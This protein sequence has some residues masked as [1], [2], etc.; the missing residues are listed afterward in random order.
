MRKLYLLLSLMVFGCNVSGNQPQSGPVAPISAEPEVN[1]CPMP[2]NVQW[3]VEFSPGGH[4]TENIVNALDHAQKTIYLQAYSFTS[5]PIA[6]ALVDAKKRGVKVLC[7]LDKSDRTGKG[8]VLPMLVG[9]G[10]P[11][12]IDEKHAIAHNKVIIIDSQTVFTGSFNFT[13]AA[14]HSNAENSIQ[15][16]D[17]KI[18]AQY[19]KNFF[20]HKEH[21]TQHSL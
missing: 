2:K 5:A 7:V 1:S 14:E 3:H 17:E 19:T 13:H 8:T 11:T 21:S 6:K 12:F 4:P 9:N 18:A 16:I 10:I 20:E 15:L